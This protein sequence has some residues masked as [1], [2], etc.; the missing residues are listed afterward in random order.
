MIKCL[1]RV[2]AKQAFFSFLVASSL[3]SPFFPF[4]RLFS[5]ITL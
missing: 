5:F 3:F 4:I 1:D 2:M